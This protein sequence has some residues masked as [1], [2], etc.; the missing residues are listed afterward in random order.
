MHSVDIW[1]PSCTLEKFENIKKPFFHLL[2]QISAKRQRVTIKP[3]GHILTHAYLAENC[4]FHNYR[5]LSFLIIF[6]V[7]CAE[8][9]QNNLLWDDMQ[10]LT[11][12]FDFECAIAQFH[13]GL[14]QG[15]R[16]VANPSPFL[17]TVSTKQ[18]ILLQPLSRYLS[19]YLSSTRLFTS[20]HHL[21]RLLPQKLHTNRGSLHKL[22]PLHPNC[23]MFVRLF[24]WFSLYLMQAHVWGFPKNDKTCI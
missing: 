6:S 16:I 13:K 5:F 4:S 23:A 1:P 20:C 21:V 2:R 11:A 14:I 24:A 3:R 10:E 7:S 18:R 12:I 9:R 22:V 8:K 15:F 17:W 19:R